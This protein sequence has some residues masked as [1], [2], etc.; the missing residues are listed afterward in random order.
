MTDMYDRI[1]PIEKRLY[2]IGI[3]TYSIL[4]LLSVIYY[5]ERVVLFDNSFYLFEMIRTEGFC[6]QRYRIISILPQIPAWLAIKIGAPFVIVSILFSAGYS[7]FYFSIYLIIGR[8]LQKYRLAL[9]LLL[10]NTL[11]VS[12]TFFWNIS[13]LYLGIGMSILYFTI[14]TQRTIE[15]LR[16]WQH[17]L[18]FFLLVF[19]TSSQPLILFPFSFL[20]V[21][22][23]KK[24][25][26]DGRVALYIAASFLSLYLVNRIYFTDWYD[27]D[28]LD[29]V[30]NIKALFPYYFNLESNYLLLKDIFSGYLFAV[31]IWMI[32][33]AF[34]LK[35]KMYIEL[36][37]TNAFLLGYLFL[38]N[39]SFPSG[40]ESFYMENMYLV[41]SMAVGSIF[42][43]DIAPRFKKFFHS[44]L[45]LLTIVIA[46]FIRIVLYQQEYAN[47]ID[48]YKDFFSKT[49]YQNI[50]LPADV[51]PNDILTMSWSVPFEVS[52]LST[53][54]Y[55]STY[56]LVFLDELNERKEEQPIFEGH[57]VTPWNRFPYDEFSKEYFNFSDQPYFVKYELD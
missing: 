43:F 15:S 2:H 35:R 13:E 24:R 26:L 23:F 29:A 53:I 39:V 12:H 10:V 11:I 54:E 37:K 49:E 16:V 31:V 30:K 38:V 8:I 55:G 21:Y 19:I 25:V 17:I 14:C 6:V 22:L 7:M 33:I 46:C 18:L 1:A 32:S 40:V 36:V 28:K 45:F 47:R 52:I 41:L 34:Y 9:V 42:I 3:L 51:A 56:G 48:W 27:A 57:F 5:Q 20:T 4:F 50:A 44:Y